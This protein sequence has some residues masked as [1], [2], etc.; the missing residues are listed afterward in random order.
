MSPLARVVV[1][2]RGINVGTAKQVRMADLKTALEDVGGTGVRTYLR[3][4][5]AVMDVPAEAAGT[6]EALAALGSA[7]EEAMLARSGVQARVLVVTAD[8]LRAVAAA[9]PFPDLVPTPKQLHVMFC[10]TAPD[11]A[12]LDAAVGLRHGDDEMAV[13]DRT[14][15]LAFRSGRSIDSPLTKVL[16]KAKIVATARNWSTVEALLGLVDA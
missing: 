1:L 12:A 11:A 14:L 3:S 8:H 7:A 6:A 10:E 5:N 16:P 13:G 15:Y 9:N 2:V 4:G